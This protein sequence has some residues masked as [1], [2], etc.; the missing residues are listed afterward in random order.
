MWQIHTCMPA[1]TSIGIGNGW[2][3]Y[4]SLFCTKTFL[5]ITVHSIVKL[6]V[7]SYPFLPASKSSVWECLFQSSTLN[8]GTRIVRAP[9]WVCCS[10]FQEML[11]S[12]QS[13]FPSASW[14]LEIFLLPRCSWFFS[15]NTDKKK[16]CTQNT[17]LI[18]VPWHLWIHWRQI[19]LVSFWWLAEA[20]TP[21]CQKLGFWDQIDLL[22]Q[23][24]EQDLQERTWYP[25]HL[26]QL[27][28]EEKA[29]IV[30]QKSWVQE[31]IM[32][33]G[34]ARVHIWMHLKE[35]TNIFNSNVIHLNIYLCWCWIQHVLV[36][37]WGC[38]MKNKSKKME[39]AW[40]LHCNGEHN[41]LLYDSMFSTRENDY[42]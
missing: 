7:R 20:S 10:L 12:K 23:L 28:W 19:F 37:R 5:F 40:L 18:N 4:K 2:H 8:C 11:L 17:V 9:D 27:V 32:Y 21:P 24:P 13:D 26:A 38:V 29:W 33:F 42:E 31:R 30:S 25:P 41:W 14:P 6:I 22:E 1:I 34:G 16:Y 39:R 3:E 36:L 15:P 35:I